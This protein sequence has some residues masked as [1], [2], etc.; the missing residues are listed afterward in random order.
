MCLI[1]HPASNVFTVTQAGWQRDYW[2]FPKAWPQTLVGGNVHF[3]EVGWGTTL[4]YPQCPLA[5]TVYI[6]ESTYS[7]NVRSLIDVSQRSAVN[8]KKFRFAWTGA[9]RNRWV[10]MTFQ[11]C[12]LA[13]KKWLGWRKRE[14]ALR[15][16]LGCWFCDT[17]YLANRFHLHVHLFSNRSLLKSKC[18]KNKEVAHE[19][20]AS[21][22][23]YCTEPTGLSM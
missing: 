12:T 4:S 18:V 1:Q 15:D 3:P 19:P 7:W 9:R 16:R 2:C 20:Q 23:R 17:Y 21:V 13:S 8:Q 11:L 6:Q 14:N 10:M 22:S 5:R